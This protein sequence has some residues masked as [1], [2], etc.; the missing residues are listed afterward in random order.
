[1]PR[2]ALTLSSKVKLIELKEHGNFN[3]KDLITRFKCGKTKL[4]NTIKNKDKI[5]DEWVNTKNSRR[6]RL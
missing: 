6:C 5:M 4:Y 3:M 2:A 1:M